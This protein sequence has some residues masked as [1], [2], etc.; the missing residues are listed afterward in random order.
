MT[1]LSCVR[2]HTE[3]SAVVKYNDPVTGIPPWMRKSFL[4][5]DMEENCWEK[6]HLENVWLIAIPGFMT[7]GVGLPLV[8]FRLLYKH[9]DRLEDPKYAFR[10]GLLYLGYRKERW[11]WEGVSAMRKVTVIMLAAFAHDDSLQLH[12][13]SGVM[14]V[15]LA[16]HSIFLPFDTSSKRSENG[17]KPKKRAVNDWGGAESELDIC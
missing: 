15:A 9:R 17:D 6:R 14:I 8:A 7:Y 5:A 10:L 2:L 3:N 13:T 4:R 16:L 12:F 11:W 1:V